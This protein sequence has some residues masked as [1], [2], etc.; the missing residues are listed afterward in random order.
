VEHPWPQLRQLV[1]SERPRTR[2]RRGRGGQAEREGGYAMTSRS[3]ARADASRLAAAL[4][5]PWGIETRAPGGRAGVW[6]DDRSQVRSGAAPQVLAA[7]R[8]LAS[9]LLRRAG[10]GCIAAVLRP[11]AGRPAGAV[12]LVRSGAGL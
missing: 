12:Q 5:G 7:G 6:D 8:N 1:R 2:L 4:R 11:L 10:K 3:A 9:T